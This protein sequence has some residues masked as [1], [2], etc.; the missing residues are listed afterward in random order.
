MRRT[1][2][3]RFARSTAPG[4]LAAAA[5][6]VLAGPAAAQW[7]QWG[8]PERNFVSAPVV[9]A[10]NWPEAGPRKLWSRE[11]GPGHSSILVDGKRLYTMCRRGDQDVVLAL[12]AETGETVWEYAYDAPPKPD[13]QLEF[14]PGPHST[15][16]IVGDRLYTVGATV[17]F[18]C[19][20][21]H[22]GKVIW[23][24]DLMKE[25]GASHLGRG[26]GASPLAWRDTVILSVGGPE[27]GLAAF[28]QDSG[29][30][31]WKSEPM[32]GGYPSPIIATIA[33]RP[34]VI[35]A[36]AAVRA[37][38]DPDTGATLWKTTVDQ[39]L[40]AIMS[41]PIF[42]A[43]DKV[44]FTCAYGG[45]SQ[46]FQIREEGGAFMPEL[47]WHSKRL[48]VQHGNAVRVGDIVVGSSGDFGPAFLMAVSLADGEMVW[49]ERGFA[50]AT[51]LLAGE[52]ML[53]LDEE[54]DL[55]LATPSR[56]G[57]T[58]HARAKLLAAKSWTV[59]TLVG[60]TLYLRDNKT[61]AA[62]DLAPGG[63]A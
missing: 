33:G 19:L 1:A 53:I 7:T 4:W 22:S 21:K 51:L 52:R 24:H 29:E 12:N 54:G 44:F 15:P 50:K 31:V 60:T 20:D 28:K 45:G 23:Q 41:T 18:H 56:E 42:V 36:L 34:Q 37:G 62:V 40:A 14:G 6:W 32:R 10:D 39:Q 46:L 5:G 38:L 49:R 48:K 26:Y 57:L 43:P 13:M 61:I 58:I 59:P 2:R 30:V 17:R 25:L 47:L 3:D 9:L 35:V 16:L 27:V 55:A 11:I 8:G 63:G